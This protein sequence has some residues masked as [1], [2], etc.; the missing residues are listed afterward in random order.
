NAQ[1]KDILTVVQPDIPAVC[2]EKKIDKRGCKG[3][4]DLIVEIVSP[5]T[6]KRDMEIK[7]NVYQKHK[8][9]E[10]WIIHPGEEYLMVFKL[11]DK[12]EYYRDG[13]FTTKDII[14]L[15]IGEELGIPLSKIF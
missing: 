14:K 11:D 4:P 15:N 5:G 9:P 10:Y 3:A 7:Y 1:D 2:A 12:N 8:V 6:V 13:I